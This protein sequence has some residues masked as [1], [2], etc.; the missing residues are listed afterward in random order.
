M[1][2][3]TLALRRAN[4]F[5]I[6]WNLTLI[7]LITQAQKLAVSGSVYSALLGVHC[8]G[9]CTGLWGQVFRYHAQ[10][11]GVRS[12]VIICDFGVRSFVIICY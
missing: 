11:F 7:T 2:D 6:N 12:F 9:L 1:G 8:A 4:T 3:L 10:D 5:P